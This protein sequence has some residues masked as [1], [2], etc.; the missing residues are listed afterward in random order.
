MSELKETIKKIGFSDKFGV[1]ASIVVGIF[2]FSCLAI[3]A[4]MGKDTVS[5]LY[6]ILSFLGVVVGFIM[7]K[8]KNENVAK[9]ENWG[10]PNTSTNISQIND[11]QTP[12]I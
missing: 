1:I 7:N 3:Y 12:T 5:Y 2:C 11:S 10:N 9:I 8:N 6:P 4:F